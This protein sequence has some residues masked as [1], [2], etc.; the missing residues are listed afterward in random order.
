MPLVLYAILAVGVV[1]LPPVTTRVA[2][3]LPRLTFVSPYIARP[4]GIGPSEVVVAPSAACNSLYPYL[5]NRF[6]DSETC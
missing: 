5:I 2:V 4:I 1:S 3:V 6:P